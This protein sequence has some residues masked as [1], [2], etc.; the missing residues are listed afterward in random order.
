MDYAP[1]LKAGRRLSLIVLRVCF[2]FRGVLFRPMAS[3][4]CLAVNS[5]PVLVL[6]KSIQG[7]FVDGFDCFY[8]NLN[9]IFSDRGLFHSDNN[10]DLLVS[11]VLPYQR[12]VNLSVPS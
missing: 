10:S 9:I 7:W 3:S 1:V 11:K 2:S 12:V 8:D 4:T 6:L 5:L